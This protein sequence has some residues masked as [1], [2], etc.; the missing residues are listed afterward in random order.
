MS[1]SPRNTDDAPFACIT[2]A[3]GW[4]PSPESVAPAV[5]PVEAV[6]N[7]IDV[8]LAALLFSGG[9]LVDVV[10]YDNLVSQDGAVRHTGDNLTGEGRGDNEMIVADLTLIDPAVTAVFVV[11]TSYTATP[12]TEIA[13]AYCRV[14]D[15]ESMAELGRFTLTGGP[16]TAVV[17]GRLDRT[18]EGWNFVGIGAGIA[19]THVTESIPYLTP[20]LP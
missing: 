8:N 19:A 16:H 10:F 2:L 11:V 9:Q 18:P 13:N 14:T 15:A 1:V 20:Y 3:L 5:D 17:L 6:E 7:R 4:D 12:F